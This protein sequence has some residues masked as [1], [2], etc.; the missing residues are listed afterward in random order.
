[1][2]DV[3]VGVGVGEISAEGVASIGLRSGR[4]RS[5]VSVLAN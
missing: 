5:V 4:L 1:M 3:L 2:V